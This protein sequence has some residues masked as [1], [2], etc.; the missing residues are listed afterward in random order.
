[1]FK[2]DSTKNIY[3]IN[4]QNFLNNFHK[5][6]DFS[7]MCEGITS[8]SPIFEKESQLPDLWLKT[9]TPF[10]KNIAFKYLGKR[11][12]K[13]G[14]RLKT[15]GQNIN[16]RPNYFPRFEKIF[17][18]NLVSLSLSPSRTSSTQRQSS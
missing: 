10:D 3:L 12:S 5:T 15:R 16:I 11:G 2:K 13:S 17:L 7:K 8:E 6:K 14:L 4:I 9:R 1:M 18:I